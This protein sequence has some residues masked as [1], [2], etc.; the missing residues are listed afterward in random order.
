MRRKPSQK[1]YAEANRTVKKNTRADKRNFVVK[2]QK[3]SIQRKYDRIV[4]YY[5]EAERP[6]KD[7]DCINILNE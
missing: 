1:E 3:R 5:Q 2:K 6:V 4:R 7:K